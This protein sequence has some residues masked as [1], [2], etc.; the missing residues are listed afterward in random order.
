MQGCRV[1]RNAG[2][3]VYSPIVFGHPLVAKGWPTD[4][5]LWRGFDEPI[6]QHCHAVLVL[7]LDSWRE[8]VGVQA[9]F[10]LARELGKP[11]AFLD[12]AII[13]MLSP[14]ARMDPNL[15]KWVRVLCGTRLSF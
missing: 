9:E 14:F 11:V 2:L 10:V 3:V 8:S 6:L 13:R 7:A 12:P 1:L 5:A 4:W 15:F